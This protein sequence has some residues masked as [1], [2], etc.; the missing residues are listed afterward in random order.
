MKF[1]NLSAEIINFF[2]DLIFFSN[3]FIQ[4]YIFFE[5][6]ESKEKIV[7]IYFLQKTLSEKFF[8]VF[9]HQCR[10]NRSELSSLKSVT[11]ER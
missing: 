7:K 3:F 5:K 2:F 4:M 11:F 1:T 8:F 9:L 10:T 6:V